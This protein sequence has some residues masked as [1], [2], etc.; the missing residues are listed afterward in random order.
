[1]ALKASI[2][3]LIYQIL[4][5]FRILSLSVMPELDWTIVSRDLV[6]T[7][8]RSQAKHDHKKNLVILE[9]EKIRVI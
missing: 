1:M 6:H 9:F 5:L 2:R 7:V 3:G 8:L 4:L